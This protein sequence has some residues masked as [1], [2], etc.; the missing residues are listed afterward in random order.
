MA[1]FYTPLRDQGNPRVFAE[2]DWLWME[3]QDSDRR[4]VTK[5]VA[6]NLSDRCARFTRRSMKNGVLRYDPKGNG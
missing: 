4:S 6:V 5:A 3:V 1:W 2:T